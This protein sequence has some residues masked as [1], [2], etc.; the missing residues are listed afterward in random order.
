M[1]A[2]CKLAPL[3]F[4]RR[5]L[6]QSAVSSVRS[7]GPMIALL[8]FLVAAITSVPPAGALQ[9]LSNTSST[10]TSS[11]TTPFRSTN[12]L[13]SRK[14][15]FK[16]ALASS[17][18]LVVVGGGK[19]GSAVAEANKKLPGLSNEAIRDIVEQD[20]LQRQFLATADFTQGLY[21]DSCTFQDEVDTYTLPKFVEGTKKLFVASKSKVELTSPVLCTEESCSFSFS[22]YLTF[23]LPLAKPTVWLSGKVVLTRSP[24]TGLFTSYRGE[25]AFGWH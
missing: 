20:V 11:S 4:F 9:Q 15:Y 13:L 8:L 12:A 7:Q 22:E 14:E 23:N 25:W 19:A 3:L 17:S 6:N 1:Q 18:L 24:S 5:R 21:E 16:A 10:P 2:R